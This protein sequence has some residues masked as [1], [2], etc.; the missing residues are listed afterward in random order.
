MQWML[1]PLKRYAQFSGRS[2]RKEYWMFILFVIIASVLIAIV[3]SILGL[4][5]MLETTGPISAMF[6]LGTLIPYI[7]VAVRRLHDTNRS[8]WWLL[9]PLIP[10]ALVVGG[11]VTMNMALAVI[12]GIA[13]FA[14]GVTVLV[15]LCLGGTDGPNRFGEDPKGGGWSEEIFA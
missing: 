3:E 6:S 2:R 1:M 12:G 15:F 8:G 5:K 10:Y 9:L 7:A 14:A 4:D 11:V 13:A